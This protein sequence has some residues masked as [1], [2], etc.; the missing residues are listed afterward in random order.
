MPSPVSIIVPAFNQ[1]EY[2]EQCVAAIQRNTPAPYKLVLIDNGSTDGVGEF[3]DAV[4]CATVVHTGENLGF[5]GGVNRGL[6][7]AEGHVVLLNSDALVATGWL[8]RMLTVLQ[9]SGDVGMVGPMSNNVSGNQ[10]IGNPKLESMDAIDAYAR[11]LAST[12]YGRHY[13]IERLVGFCLLI[14]NDVLDK[15]GLLDER[16]GIGNF[17][18]D[19]YCRRVRAAGYRLCVAEDAFVYHYGSRTFRAMGITG[20]R[21]DALIQ[22]NQT[23]YTAKWAKQ[24]NTQA[25]EAL[26]AGDHATAVRALKAAIKTAPQDATHYNDLAVVLWETGEREQAYVMAAKGLRADRSY[27]PARDNLLAMAAAR[28]TLQTMPRHYWRNWTKTEGPP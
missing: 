5:A 19:D 4:P 8:D 1:L 20:E 28:W 22:D 26:A 27:A 10:Q 14:R 17:E 7:H 3:F 13:D 21:W 18:D 25:R 6:E 11:E 9:D 12:K 23:K 16:F 24:S 15:V 2:C